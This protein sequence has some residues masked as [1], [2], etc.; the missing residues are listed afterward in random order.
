MMMIITFTTRLQIHLNCFSSDFLPSFTGQVILISWYW[1]PSTVQSSPVQPSLDS[2]SLI[3][4]CLIVLSC[5]FKWCELHTRVLIHF[6]C[7]QGWLVLNLE[8]LVLDVHISLAVLILVTD[9]RHLAPRI[10][11]R[12]KGL[13]GLL[14]AITRSFLVVRAR[15]L[16][17]LLGVAAGELIRVDDVVCLLVRFNHFLL[18]SRILSVSCIGDRIWIWLRTTRLG[19]PLVVLFVESRVVLHR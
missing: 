14:R 19:R 6:D 4:K 13:L 7:S 8:L 15:H 1:L 17:L 16:W 5:R 2:L 12:C 11:H 18:L 10:V 3:V 9:C